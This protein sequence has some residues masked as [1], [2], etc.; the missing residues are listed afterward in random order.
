MN[1][2]LRNA[3]YGAWQLGDGT[4]VVKVQV[5]P[6][7]IITLTDSLVKSWSSSVSQRGKIAR[8]GTTIGFR[9]YLL[10][11][12]HDSSAVNQKLI[13]IVSHSKGRLPAGSE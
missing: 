5:F 10:T 3:S 13:V 6:S 12:F 8:G 9:P 2:P 11:Y 4:P 1:R 7:E